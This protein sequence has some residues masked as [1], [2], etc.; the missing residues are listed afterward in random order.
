[1]SVEPVQ[2]NPSP[3]TIPTTPQSLAGHPEPNWPNSAKAAANNIGTE[4]ISNAAP[5]MYRPNSPTVVVTVGCSRLSQARN[6]TMATLGA[7]LV[8]RPSVC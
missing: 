6:P 3:A 4:T 7:L 5:S 1:M 8:N 2:K